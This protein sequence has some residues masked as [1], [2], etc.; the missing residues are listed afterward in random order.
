MA[1]LREDPIDI[2]NITFQQSSILEQVI[3]NSGKML[4]ESLVK[5]ERYDEVAA[6]SELIGEF[7]LLASVYGG[8]TD[9]ILESLGVSLGEAAI[10]KLEAIKRQDASMEWKHYAE[11][12]KSMLDELET[13]Q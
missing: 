13:R 12:T 8:Q 6:L 7:T 11:D 5:A 10:F 2:E 3:I 1:S 4:Y 9:R